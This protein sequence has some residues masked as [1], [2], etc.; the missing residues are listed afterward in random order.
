MNHDKLE[1]GDHRSAK[2]VVAHT[3]SG[4]PSFASFLRPPFLGKSMKK[5][6]KLHRTSYLDGVRGFAALLV[7]LLHHAQFAHLADDPGPK[8]ETA[9]SANGEY[10]F[11][12]FPII[13]NFFTG[14]HYAVTVFFVISGYVLS[15]KSLSLIQAGDYVPLGDTVAS[16]LYRRFPRLFIPMLIVTISVVLMGRFGIVSLYTPQPTLLGDLWEWYKEFK[17]ITWIYQTSGNPFFTYNPHTWSLP[18]EWRGSVVIYGSIMAFS[19]ASR[20]ARLWSEIGLMFYFIYIADGAVYG[21]FIAGM[22]IC[23]LDLLAMRG[24]LPTWMVRLKPFKTQIFYSMFILSLLL[25]GVPAHKS[26][27]HSLEEEPFWKYLVIFKPQAVWDTKWF[28]LFWAASL[29]I[30]SVRHISWAKRFFESWFCQYL[31]RVSYSFYLVHGP[32]LWTIGERVYAMFGLGGWTHLHPNISNI[33]P[34]PAIA[35]F[36]GAELNYIAAQAVLLPFTLWVGEL[37]TVFV[38]DRTI[39]F[40]SW[41]YKDK[42]LPSK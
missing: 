27:G 38:D 5:D 2:E 20:N 29:L 41:L 7:Y 42:V 16:A 4:S 22:F 15:S 9:W 30:A 23:D 26:G 36:Y 33:I 1:R 19:R 8:M 25:G 40:C 18:V 28:F 10:Y 17:G 34:I 3:S 11:V 12:A 13:R 31:G 35:P 6:A 32:I 39:K 37:V 14:G 24:E 21:M